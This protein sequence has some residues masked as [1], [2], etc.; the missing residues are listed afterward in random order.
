[1]WHKKVDEMVKKGEDPRSLTDPSAQ[2]KRKA[3]LKEE[4]TKLK[5][6]REEREEEKLQMDE[7]RDRADREREM[8]EHVG[9]EAKE[10]K[11]HLEMAKERTKIR[12]QE[13]RAKP[14]DN[15]AKNFLL[16]D[17]FD[18]ALKEPWKVFNKLKLAEMKELREGI[19]HYSSLGDRVEYWAALAAVG[20]DEME[21][22]RAKDETVKTGAAGLAIQEGIHTSV[23]EQVNT[24]FEGKSGAELEELNDQIEGHIEQG[25]AEDLEYW[26]NLLK[27][28]TVHRAKA[29]LREVQQQLVQARLRKLTNAGEDLFDE[30]GQAKAPPTEEGGDAVMMPPPAD[31]LAKINQQ[32]D[33][34]EQA[35]EEAEPDASGGWSPV[36]L[37]E[38][39]E[40]E[41]ELVATAAEDLDELECL[42]RAVASLEGETVD[43]GLAEA[44]ASSAAE[45]AL[46]AKEHARALSDQEAGEV[47]FGEANAVETGGAAQYWWAEKYKARKPRYFNRI[48]TGYEW[49]KYNQTHYDHDN[50]PPKVVQGYKFNVFYPDLIDKAKAPVYHINPD[51]DGNPELCVIRFSAGPP[52]EDIAF[53]VVN[54]EWEY[55]HK[56]GYKCTFDRGVLHLFFNFKRHRYR[57]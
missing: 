50:P 2:K 43:T 46:F 51:P 30:E 3:E 18:M 6:R 44:H 38:L 54:R 28:L 27:R 45:D 55:S 56:K 53:K 57:R 1:V 20:D 33:A 34:H 48:H 23:T 9:W 19:D 36:L 40:G 37:D 4:I 13:K 11:F 15:L 17:H 29:T 31:M 21:K 10:D 14:I 42:R 7:E 5:K 49:N 52:Y 22:L 25:G 47:A 39:P 26:Q 8:M 32:R 12:L 41:E 24:M 16:D 35:I